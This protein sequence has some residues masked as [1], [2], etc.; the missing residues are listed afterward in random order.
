M[1]K[2]AKNI[3]NK[4]KTFVAKEYEIIAVFGF[5][6]IV[7]LI[8]LR[9]FYP[10][11]LTYDSIYQWNQ[12]L[13]YERWDNFVP[14]LH[15]LLIAVSQRI[16]ETPAA[17][18]LVHTGLIS[19]IVAFIYRE[20]RQLK[21]RLVYRLFFVGFTLIQPTLLI[22]NITLWKDVMYSYL[23]FLQIPLFLYYYRTKK[24]LNWKDILLISFLAAI[25]VSMRHNGVPYLA[26]IPF[27][28][29][30]L[31]AVN[32]R[33]GAVLLFT[34]IF[35]YFILQFV[36]IKAF[37]AHNDR[38]P[39]LERFHR[40]QFLGAIINEGV[41]LD[42]HQKEVISEF[43]PDLDIVKSC[44]TCIH[45]NW[46]FT[47]P[48]TNEDVFRESK[49]V[50]EFDHVTTELI[51]QNPG[52]VLEDRMCM[53]NNLFGYGEDNNYLYSSTVYPNDNGISQTRRS[54]TDNFEDYLKFTTEMPL[55]LIFWFH[56]LTSITY[57][58]GLIFAF[59]KKNWS[60]AAVSILLL[61]NLPL[62]FAI[63]IS[64]DFRYL[65]IL[66]LA[67][68]IYLILLFSK[69]KIKFNLKKVNT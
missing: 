20:L 31:Q 62:F 50:K 27:C 54:Y 24:K 16:W 39:Y 10:G 60:L 49:N 34:T 43:I 40:I 19:F 64:N 11:V 65:F 2:K 8:W 67:F 59:L 53:F 18:N 28:Y 44:Y 15:T 3:L 9:A 41:E 35:V 42:E 7:L 1:E 17:I 56:G 61:I 29:W 26:V 45:A 33:K 57:I 30:V 25:A 36:V 48:V 46:I 51:I 47:C 68:P 69:I 22:Y 5:T 38:L 32:I 63:D 23:L 66:Q 37:P 21:V 6:V 58:L 12:A 13:E 4:V 14:Y 55:R 52:I